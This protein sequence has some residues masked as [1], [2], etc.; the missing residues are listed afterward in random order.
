MNII[1]SIFKKELTDVLRDRRTLFF[2][3]VIPVIVLPLIIIGSIKFQEYQSKKSDE[4]VLNL[5]LIHI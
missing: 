4:K 2:M 1:F 5:S 3:I